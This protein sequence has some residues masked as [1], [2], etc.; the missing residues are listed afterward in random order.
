LLPSICVLISSR[1]AF[2][3]TPFTLDDLEATLKHTGDDYNP[4]IDVVHAAMISSCR[5]ISAGA[6]ARPQAAVTSLQQLADSQME[7]DQEDPLGINFE[8]LME[9]LTVYGGGWEKKAVNPE[10]WVNA[11]VCI[12]KEVSVSP[13]SWK[14]SH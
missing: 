1:S 4:L 10:T 7:T 14:P 11:M 5:S 6:T 9:T 12:L 2:N 8:T 3:I 13:Y